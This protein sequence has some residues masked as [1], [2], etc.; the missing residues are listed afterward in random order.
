MTHRINAT[1]RIPQ[2]SLQEAVNTICAAWSTKEQAK[3][4]V[5]SLIGCLGIRKMRVLTVTSSTS[6]LDRPGVDCAET[7]N[8]YGSHTV[9]DWA[10][11]CRLVGPRST[12]PAHD[13]ILSCEA[14]L[15]GKMIYV[16]GHLTKPR[17]LAEFKTDSCLFEAPPTKAARYASTLQAIKSVSYTHLRAHET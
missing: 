7:K 16:L 15:V 12:R 14:A 11:N 10:T 2:R 5:N 1:A 13:T 8:V 4:S 6:P 3:F 9:Y 17:C